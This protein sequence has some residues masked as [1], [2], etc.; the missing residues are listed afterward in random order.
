MPF[1]RTALVVGAALAALAAVPVPSPACPFCAS[2]GQTLTGEV[3]QADLIVIGTMTNVKRDPTDFTQGST[4]IVI[5][6]VIKP[7]AFLTGK[8][9]LVMPR[10]I[11]PPA[12][13]TKFMVFGTLYPR[14]EE[15]PT[16]GL[17]SA[18]IL[19]NPQ[20]AKLDPYKGVPV[21]ADSKLPGYLAG[22]MAVRGK[23]TVSRLRYFFDFLDSADIEVA[24]DA[25]NEF[26]ASEYGDVRKLSATLPAATIVKWMQDP[27]TPPSRFGLYGLMLGHCG[28]PEDAKAVRAVLDQ[29]DRL[30][31]SGLDGMLAAYVMLD[32]PAG[33]KYLTDL[34]KDGTKEFPVRY[35]ALKVL[36]FF[37]EYRPDLA[38]KDEVLAGVRDLVAQAD[39]ADIPIEDLRKWGRWDQLDYVL[40]FGPKESHSKI[41][42][43]RRAILRFALAAPADNKLASEYVAKARAEN[44]QWV[45]D[46]EQLLKDELK[47]ATP[48]VP[49]AP[50]PPATP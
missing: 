20:F 35:A 38:S 26:A 1:R 44:P 46:V 32:R 5:D 17:A 13:G 3:A 29:P 39:M 9:I 19:G 31:S 7:N 37:W 47:P 16:A 33:M 10:P 34:L 23:D 21:K 6:R 4:D 8:K 50:K 30:Y 43:V 41:P 49:S 28:K 40:G 36:R 18:A 11:E 25:M 22:A 15:F 48:A 14:P 45:R 2:Q 42:I 12:D 24:A 27:D